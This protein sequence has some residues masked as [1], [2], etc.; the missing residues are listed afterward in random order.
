MTDSVRV[1]LAVE[2]DVTHIAEIET[3]V[4]SDPW[5]EASLN[6]DLKDDNY[7]LLCL[8]NGGVISAYLIGCDVAGE[9]ELL[10][11]AVRSDFRRC[12]FGRMLTEHFINE[13]KDAGDLTMFL[14]V[15]AS[16]SSAISLYE[17]CGFES[18][19]VRRGYY[20]N[21]TEDAVIMRLDLGR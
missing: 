12:G 21:P 1:R 6:A 4:F 3:E 17:S 20:K 5:S 7:T 10:R 13:R 2:A 8:E 16:N 9:S 15:R 18:Y 14:E 19:T 11:V